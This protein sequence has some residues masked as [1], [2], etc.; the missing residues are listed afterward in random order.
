MFKFGTGLTAVDFSDHVIAGTYEVNNNPEYSELKDARYVVH[1]KKLRDKV[2]GSF[3]MWFKNTTDYASFLSA[4]NSA[5]SSSNDSVQV[6][7]CVNNTNT[8]VTI[9]AYINYK[10]VRNRNGKW[11][12]YFERFKVTIEER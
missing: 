2:S 5:K 10:L 12:D 3:E 8:E 1:K 6:T 11:Q 4:L 7:L 9:Y